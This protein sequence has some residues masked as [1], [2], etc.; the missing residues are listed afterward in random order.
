MYNSLL[1]ASK[2]GRHLQT[3]KEAPSEK[4]VI[5]LTL[6]SSQPIPSKPK[7]KILPSFCACQRRRRLQPDKDT[8]LRSFFPLQSTKLYEPS[9]RKYWRWRRWQRRYVPCLR[10]EQLVWHLEGRNII[11][12]CRVMELNPWH[13]PSVGRLV[14][15][16]W[17]HC[18]LVASFIRLVSWFKYLILSQPVSGG[19]VRGMASH[20]QGSTTTSQNL[21]L[22]DED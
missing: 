6:T 14:G 5:S 4:V 22:D 9:P 2:T 15:Q 17:Q 19:E 12:G 10:T 16:G 7:R 18:L 13:R 3:R 1:T 20:S 21:I 8:A 11:Y